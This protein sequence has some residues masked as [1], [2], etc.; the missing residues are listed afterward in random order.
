MKT[1]DEK[2]NIQTVKTTCG[3]L[4][5][6]RDWDKF[7][8]GIVMLNAQTVKRYREIQDEHPDADECGVFF[9]FSNEQFSEGYRHLVE[10]GHIKEG[11]KV[12]QSVGGAF[13]TKEGLNKF[14]QFYEDRDK[15]IKEECDPQEVYFYEYNN[16]ES[17][18]AWDG[19]LEA[20]KIII[21]IWGADVARRIVRY[22]VSMS[23]DNIIRKPVKMEGLYFTYKG[24]KRVPA[25]L[26]FSDIGNDGQR[27]LCYSMYDNALHIVLSS[28]GNPYCNEDLAGLNAS[29]DNVLI[30]NFHVE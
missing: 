29:Y 6:Y 21:D 7:E 16:H 10:L 13:G 3:E 30:Y 14:F 9:A 18:I 26:W 12:I 17:M 11:D 27:G 23:V 2:K 20:I 28:D 22:D 5:Y 24:E 15:P 1:I 19:D 25:N 8:G 4:Q